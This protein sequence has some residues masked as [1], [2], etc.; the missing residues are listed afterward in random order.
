MNEFNYIC[1]HEVFLKTELLALSLRICFFYMV[2]TLKDKLNP[3]TMAVKTI[4]A[5]VF[6]ANVEIRLVQSA[7]VWSNSTQFIVKRNQVLPKKANLLYRQ[8]MLKPLAPIKVKL[9]TSNFVEVSMTLVI[10]SFY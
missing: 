3:G 4:L 10:L 2:V 9:G 7:N 8:R 6:C 1:C 5:I